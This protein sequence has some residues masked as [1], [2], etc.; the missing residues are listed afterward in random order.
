MR[1]VVDPRVLATGLIRPRGSP[2]SVLARLREGRFVSVVS[3]AMLDETVAVLSQ[4]WL[5]D[6][7]GIDEAAVGTLLRFLL[8]RSELVKPPSEAR[9]CRDPLD[10]KLLDAALASRADR[11]LTGGADLLALRGFEGVKILD[12]A[13]FA[14]EIE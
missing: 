8:L 9:R 13:T 1:A 6:K 7:Y 14:G 12:P 11:L 4:P 3:P 5:C 2:A 10:D